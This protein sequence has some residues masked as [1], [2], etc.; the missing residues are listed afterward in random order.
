MRSSVSLLYT[1]R[2]FERTKLCLSRR[3]S[4]LLWMKPS[5]TDSSRVVRV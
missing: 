3:K 5:S 2:V 4:S 1:L